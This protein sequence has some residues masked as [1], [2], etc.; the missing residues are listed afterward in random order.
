LKPKP[1]TATCRKRGFWSTCRVYFRRFRITVW[2][3][4]LAL[5]G[6]LVYLTQVGLPDFAKRP[7][8]E[9]LRTRGL[10]L[11]FSRL[12]L[13]WYYGI[14]AE[15][16]R[17]GQADEPLSP[18]LTAARV[19]LRLNH[20]AL[21]RLQ[22][23]VNSVVLRNGRLI[24]PIAE[25][26][27]PPRQLTVENIQAELRL[28]PHDEWS[29]DHFKADF[30]GARIQISGTVAHA[31]AVRQWRALQPKQA[32]PASL[33]RSRLRRFNDFMGHLQFRAPPALRLDVRGDARDL[34]SF[35]VRVLLSA[36]AA[37]TPWGKFSQGRFSARLFPADTNGLSS[38]ELSLEAGEAQTRWATTANLQ[39]AAHVGSF[40]SL[41]NLG[42]GDLTLCASRVETEWGCATNV[43]LTL[44][45]TSMEGHTNWI[46][47]DLV[48]V[49]GQLATRWG[50]A[51]NAHFAA[52]W[53][54]EISSAVPLDG[55]C[56][57][58][59]NHAITDWGTARELELDAHLAAPPLLGPPRADE[60]WGAWGKLEPYALDWDARAHGVQARGIEAER[61]T[62]AGTWRA[63]Q[64]TI[65]NLHV[66]LDHQRLDAH[67]GLDV[68]TRALDATVA[69]DIDP[70]KFAP[71]LPEEARRELAALSWGQPP[72]LKAQAA[73]VL[74]AWTNRQ[75]NWEAEVLPTLQLQGEVNLPQGGAYRDVSVKAVQSH[76]SY[77]NRL[78]RLPDLA[79]VR[80]EGMLQ[81]A[82]EADDRTQDF[83]ARIA[84]SFDLTV[85][86]PLLGQGPQKGLD[87]FT[88][89]EPPVLDAEI[90]GN[91]RE[92]ERIG[93]KGRLAITNF[94][95]RGES[96]TG[97]QTALQFTNNV[98]QFTEPRI[99]R[100]AQQMR[101]DG[102]LA[103]FNAE[104]VFLTN[105][106]STAEPMVIARAIGPQTAHTVEPFQFRQPPIAYVHGT[107]PMHGEDA[108][109]L[110][111]DLDGGPF[112][113]WRFHLPR[114]VGH[115]HWR[116]QHLTLT[117]VW[118][119][120]YGGQAAGWAAFD[121]HPKD[122]ADYQFTM[123]ITNTLL[124]PLVKDT[125]LTTNHMEGRLTGSLV[126]NRANTSDIRS[127]DGY[128]D[129]TLRDGLIW[130][131]P[132]FGV[133]SGVLNGMS[134]G[135]GSS[136]ASAGTCTFGITNGIIRSEDLDIRS[137]GMRLQY[138]GTLDFQGQVNAR[139]EAGLL[140]DMWLVGPLVST[141]FWPVTKLFEYKVTGTLGEPK[142]E[143]VN[144]LPKVVLLPFQMPF[145]PLRT[146]R[147]LLP[148][149]I[150]YSPTNAPPLNAPKQN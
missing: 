81:A 44:L 97:L 23:Q 113:W 147:G 120:F 27:E 50:S 150:G 142:T 76:L 135:L 29:L 65:T 11:Q 117:N 101:A 136:R 16:V 90:W 122:D 78:W 25:T 51:T 22:L 94:T 32:A 118:A 134:P 114:V 99:Q 121:F 108:A 130:E 52:Q 93:V 35:G 17:F 141:V 77:S 13:S 26:N 21:A 83:H 8:L 28:L 15:N 127:W 137:T 124:Q 5:V 30:A 86:R 14:L 80:P 82:V 41:T 148:D 48:A 74:P 138:R 53:V 68:A 89:T 87:F 45:G 71:A 66:E 37:D 69:T 125:F 110:H 85:L 95:F 128:G 88:F 61:L 12:R 106:F 64:L 140:R 43:Q 107:I 132:I 59:C 20:H 75:A 36:A 145:H 91:V 109:D 55:S 9:N 98:L 105:G 131:I 146:L 40:V 1:P 119:D 47:A 54:H 63:P 6:A 7:L 46:S 129:A 58:S 115:V 60:S 42:N 102:L 139:V 133:F 2:L 126:V 143:P 10:D 38:A 84:S 62:C 72:A 31:S 92:P 104:L 4:V 49:T 79:V 70:H 111:F 56:K 39:L 103:D 149:T 144:I 73:L 33:W 116:G 100:G 19:Q 24:W 34:S 57:F 96:A 112:E 123:A 18:Q 3:L 67:G